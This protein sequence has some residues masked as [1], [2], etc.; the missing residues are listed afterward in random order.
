MKDNT[1]WLLAAGAAA[2]LFWW[3]KRPG[4][5]AAEASAALPGP[6]G[7]QDTALPPES[8]GRLNG[9]S[10]TRPQVSRDWG[11]PQGVSILRTPQSTFS[12]PQGDRAITRSPQGHNLSSGPQG[13]GQVGKVLGFGA[14][15]GG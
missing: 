13:G 15:L 7:E 2:Y 8:V 6:P 1:L 10:G 3:K 12:G 11:R 4:T 14:G 9:I 5:P